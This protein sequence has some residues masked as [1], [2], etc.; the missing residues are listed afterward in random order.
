MLNYLTWQFVRS[1]FLVYKK[2][3]VHNLRSLLHFIVK[4][5]STFIAKW[6]LKDQVQL[7]LF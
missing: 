5:E 2:L 4:I 3:S 6:K 1:N 7:A